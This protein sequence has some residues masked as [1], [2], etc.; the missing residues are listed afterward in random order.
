MKLIYEYHDRA[1]T[2][3]Y[4][5]TYIAESGKRYEACASN[6]QAVRAN[7]LGYIKA[8]FSEVTFVQSKPPHNV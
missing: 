4:R 7:I 5:C 3:P 1:L 2:P 8:P 6:R